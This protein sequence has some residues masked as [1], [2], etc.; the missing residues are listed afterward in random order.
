MDSIVD[1]FF[2][3]IDL[4]E[5]EFKD[6]SAFLADPLKEAGSSAS[7][8]HF[9]QKRKARASRRSLSSRLL[10]RAVRHRLP[11]V[12]LPSSVA[13]VLSF[14]P[15]VQPGGKKEK[16]VS[17]DFYNGEL[18]PFKPAADRIKKLRRRFRFLRHL[19]PGRKSPQKVGRL[20]RGNLPFSPKEVLQRI[21]QSRRIVVGL[22]RLLVSK[23]DVT[24][25]MRKRSQESDG[26]MGIYF[27]DLEGA[28]PLSLSLSAGLT[29]ATFRSRL[30]DAT[31][32]ELL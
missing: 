11:S 23:T 2:P 16:Q 26:D 9:S 15:F 29:P 4:I 24:R 22:L 12:S 21:T 5:D 27:S 14:L 20:I 25:A 28:L 13:Y 1:A 6:I 18:V 3:L 17:L 8:L 10:P 19:T 30:V 31:E 32:P 7:S